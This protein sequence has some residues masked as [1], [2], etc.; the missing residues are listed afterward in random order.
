MLLQQQLST[1]VVED[2]LKMAREP[3]EG[4]NSGSGDSDHEWEALDAIRT[5]LNSSAYEGMPD[6]Q[7]ALDV[8]TKIYAEQKRNSDDDSPPHERGTGNKCV[9]DKEFLFPGNETV[10]IYRHYGKNYYYR[11][12]DLKTN[13]WNNGETLHAGTNRDIAYAKGVQQ[14]IERQGKKVRGVLQKSINCRELVRRYLEHEQK[15][16]KITTARGLT[17]S[18]FDAKVQRLQYWQSYIKEHG[19]E[20]RPVEDIPSHIGD[21]FASWIDDQPK[22]V[23]KG[24]PRDIST[25][26]AIVSATKAMYH[27]ANDRGYIGHDDIPKFKYLDKKAGYD[28]SE[29]RQILWQDEWNQLQNHLLARSKDKQHNEITRAKHEQTY[30]YFRLA[31]TTGMRLREINNLRWNQII[32]PVHETG[33]SRELKRSIYIPQTKT[34]RKRTITAEVTQIFNGLH[35]LYQRRGIEINRNSDTRVFFKLHTHRHDID[36]WVTDKTMVERLDAAMKEI[37]LYQ[38]LEKEMPPRRITPNSSRHYCATYLKVNDGWTWEDIAMHLGHDQE[39]TQKRYAKVTSA[40]ISAK[41]KSKTGLA[42]IDEYVFKDENGNP[43]SEIGQEIGKI[44]LTQ[45][46][47]KRPDSFTYEITNGEL[48]PIMLLS[49]ED[50]ETI[51]EECPKEIELRDDGSEWFVIEDDFKMLMRFKS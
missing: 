28:Q 49:K 32:V 29:E 46:A 44:L 27:W 34:G 45:W 50:Y 33:H 4:R 12:K 23:Y 8:I 36:S 41:Q 14:Y 31:Y 7:V 13:R 9:Q 5:L 22:Q 17:Q 1:S 15:R 37:G 42:A 16:I 2:W 6:A 43:S 26:N 40:M 30:W 21:L 38:K 18:S 47:L 20:R 24:R 51:K 3:Q 11:E 39:Q 35:R 19:H 10:Y 48:A 25:I